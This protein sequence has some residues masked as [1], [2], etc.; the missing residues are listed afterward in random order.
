VGQSISAVCEGTLSF[1]KERKV[2]LE[3][4]QTLQ[5]LVQLDLRLI[6]TLRV[7]SSRP[8]RNWEYRTPAMAAG[9]TDRVW[10]VKEFNDL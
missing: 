9:I 5:G 4:P 1:S 6:V 8:G 2:A 10:T 3:S 7:K